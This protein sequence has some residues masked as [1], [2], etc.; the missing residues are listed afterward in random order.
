MA[1]FKL[2]IKTINSYYFY[3][4]YTIILADKLV[5]QSET[6]M[7]ELK[8]EEKEIEILKL[9]LKEKESKEV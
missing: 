4:F 9:I 7:S 6:Q 2:G 1:F 8:E 5:F 3:Y